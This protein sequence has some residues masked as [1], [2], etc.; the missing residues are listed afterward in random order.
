MVQ[1][2]NSVRLAQYVGVY[3][4]MAAVAYIA[5]LL[6]WPRVFMIFLGL[7]YVAPFYTLLVLILWWAS[8]RW[9]HERFSRSLA[10]T[11]LVL[12]AVLI[13][14]LL[15]RDALTTLYLH[16]ASPWIRIPAKAVL[17]L[18]LGLTSWG[19]LRRGRIARPW[20]LGVYGLLVVVPW[21]ASLLGMR[22]GMMT[23]Q[24]NPNL[25]G[26][27]YVGQVS[28]QGSQEKLS[29][30]IFDPNHATDGVNVLTYRDHGL[31]LLMDMDGTVLHQWDLMTDSD[32]GESVWPYA[33]LLDRGDILAFRTDFILERV[34]LNSKCRWVASLRVHHAFHLLDCGELYVLARRDGVSLWHGLPV[35]SVEDY[36]AVFDLDGR[37]RRQMSVT[38]RL[39]GTVRRSVIAD[40]YQ[41]ILA[42]KRLWRMIRRG[43]RGGTMFSSHTDFD[44]L[45]TNSVFV[46]ESP[47]PGLCEPGSL[48]VSARNTDCIAILEPDGHRVVWQWGPGQIDGQHDAVLLDNGHIRLFDNGIDR[49]WSRVIDMDPASGRIVWQYPAEPN[50]AFYSKVRGSCQTLG[51]GNILITES[52]RGRAFEITRDG[53]IVWEYYSPF[54]NEDKTRRMSIYRV[55][56][57]AREKVP[58]VLLKR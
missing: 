52:E 36:V 48:L 49:D 27:G 57:F 50:T 58:A 32:Q 6:N 16:G 45:H 3:I 33:Y 38:R 17:A 8:R 25:G 51:N 5:A 40:V 20:L 1:H 2:K 43:L 4:A 10:A 53:R 13:L 29:V 15:G 31:A 11:G 7:L 35:P 12:L 44:L 55:L 22:G 21:A 46:I 41:Q 19:L 54:V 24:T 30:T 28:A 42:P 9:M 14:F 37:M 18:C 26:I 39:V 23:N 47:P 56:R 34:A